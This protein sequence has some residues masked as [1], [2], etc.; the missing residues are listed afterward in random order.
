MDGLRGKE[1]LG[2]LEYRRTR[3]WG[4]VQHRMRRGLQI[5]DRV[6]EGRGKGVRNSAEEGKGGR[7]GQGRGH[8]CDDHMKLESFLS[9]VDWTDPR[10]P[11]AASAA[12]IGKYETLRVFVDICLC[13]QMRGCY[14]PGRVSGALAAGASCSKPSLAWCPS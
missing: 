8:T 14:D 10:T 1:C 7:E 12:S 11:E 2:E 4:L 5:Y 9:R 3:P 13:A 6:S